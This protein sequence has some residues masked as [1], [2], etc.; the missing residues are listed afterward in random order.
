M[1][2]LRQRLERF[3]RRHFWLTVLYTLIL[4]VMAT[5]ILLDQHEV[6]GILYEGF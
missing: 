3:G 1:I 2:A 4:A 6:T 5:L